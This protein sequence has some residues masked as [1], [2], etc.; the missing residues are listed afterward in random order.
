[1]GM[2][3]KSVAAVFEIEFLPTC[4]FKRTQSQQRLEPHAQFYPYSLNVMHTTKNL[5]E[6][7]RRLGLSYL[8]RNFGKKLDNFPIDQ[9]RLFMVNA[10]PGICNNFNVH[11]I[12]R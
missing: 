3:W 11:L 10:M 12:D 6:P 4:K 5:E 9:V 8:H 2:G 7:S 1:M